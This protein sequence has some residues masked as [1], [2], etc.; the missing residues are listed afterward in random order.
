MPVEISDWKPAPFAMGDEIVFAIGDIHGCAV[1]LRDLLAS[2]AALAA[3][4]RHA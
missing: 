1:E 2:I 3:E 4:A